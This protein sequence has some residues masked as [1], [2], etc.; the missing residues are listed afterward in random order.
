MNTILAQKKNIP[1]DRCV[2]HRLRFFMDLEYNKS[3]CFDMYGESRYEECEKYENY[4]RM[5]CDH[6]IG[7]NFLNI[8]IQCKNECHAIINHKITKA[9]QIK[10]RNR[11]LLRKE[12]I[13]KTKK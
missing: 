13:K 8:R 1:Y 12:F 9:N 10:L 3:S 5:C 2:H 4:C 7:A 11:Q 6:H